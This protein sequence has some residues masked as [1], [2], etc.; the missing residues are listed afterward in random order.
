MTRTLT[1]TTSESSVFAILK[2]ALIAAI[3]AS[4]CTLKAAGDS[5]HKDLDEMAPVA[6]GAQMPISDLFANIDSVDGFKQAMTTTG[7]RLMI[8]VMLFGEDS[9]VAFKSTVKGMLVG[10]IRLGFNQLD[11]AQ[12]RDLDGLDA[13]VIEILND[14]FRSVA[15]NPKHALKSEVFVKGLYGA[16]LGG[17]FDR[18]D[19]N[20]TPEQKLLFHASLVR[21]GKML[22]NVTV[23]GAK[24]ALGIE[25]AFD[26]LVD[27]LCV[28]FGSSTDGRAEEPF[29][30]VMGDNGEVVISQAVKPE[31]DEQVGQV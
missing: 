31:T 21:S 30:L 1:I 13:L 12:N 3:F 9:K 8:D 2:Y 16:I 22:T 29:K 28:C 11:D 6:I 10:A 26:K 5:D 20:M 17:V 27:K 25:S 19:D 14:K 24:F 7:L 15:D 23:R 18:Y 4:V